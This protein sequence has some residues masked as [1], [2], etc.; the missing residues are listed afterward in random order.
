MS[1]S[2]HGNRTIICLRC[3][4]GCEV[5]AGIDEQGDI[6][7]VTGNVCKLGV[8]YVTQEIRDPRRI[9]PT[10]VRV[11]GGMHPLVAVWTPQ[12]IPKGKLLELARESR[13]IVLD[14]PVCDGQVVLHDW[15]HLGIDL[16]TSGSVDE[17]S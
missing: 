16:V 11:R 2:K 12:P 10:T 3:P 6:T 4:R 1:S 8:E 5:T 13:R 17:A 15:Q 7:E 14:A 9:L